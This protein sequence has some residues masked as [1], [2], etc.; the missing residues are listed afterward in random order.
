VKRLFTEGQWAQ[1]GL[2]VSAGALAAVLILASWSNYQ[3]AHDTTYTLHIGE[4]R[5]FE[6]EIMGALRHRDVRTDPLGATALLDSVLAQQA[7]EGLRYVA[8]LDG[9]DAVVA[10]A[11][12]SLAG[13]IVGQSE[14]GDEPGHTLTLVGSR[15]RVALSHPRGPTLPNVPVRERHFG[16]IVFEFEPLIAIHLMAR[17]GRLLAFGLAAA[18]LMM[19]VAAV[20]W[21]FSRRYER[22][23]RRLEHERRLS[24]IGEMSAVLAH[25]I[26][27]PL[28]SLKGH[29][30]LLAERLAPATSDRDKAERVVLEATRLEA[31]TADLLDFV[32][33]GPLDRQPVDPAALLRAAAEEV[34][35]E[36]FELDLTGA[37][38]RWPV[39]G[40]RLHQALTNLLR[41]AR[42]ASTSGAR[43]PVVGMNVAG[44]RLVVTL[45]DFG[46]GLPKGQEDR[47]FDPFFTTRATG[48]GLGLAVARRIV[49]LHG[50]QLTATNHA[51]GG[52]LFRMAL[53]GERG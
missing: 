46:A 33:I 10:S 21:Q 18:A 38:E 1:W 15:V 29:A 42:Q 2:L 44:E 36:G 35:P 9:S 47:V 48:T 4:A 50:G 20:S 7:S 24:L 25:E 19:F 53:P 39:D 17:A 52:A 23:L 11:G 26:R 40:P 32:R 14:P 31:L 51:E 30:Q 8:L 27:N 43:P 5:I 37:P 12:A 45:R 13:P 41:N 3:G 6:R 34:D 49:E 16:G 28:A 22:A